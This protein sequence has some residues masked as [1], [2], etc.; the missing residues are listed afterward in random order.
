MGRWRVLRAHRPSR[1]RGLA[2]PLSLSLSFQLQLQ[3]PD[4]RSYD[5][6]WTGCSF[7]ASAVVDDFASA[8]PPGPRAAA[9]ATRDAESESGL[10]LACSR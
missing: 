7:S 9:A 1:R 10:P 2:G 3:C 5:S 8:D 4:G 6:T